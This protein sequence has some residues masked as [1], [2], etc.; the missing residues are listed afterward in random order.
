MSVSDTADFDLI[1]VAVFAVKFGHKVF[2]RRIDRR[3]ELLRHRSAPVEEIEGVVQ[4]LSDIRK[5]LRLLVGIVQHPVRR[6]NI[7]IKLLDLTVKLAK[8]NIKI[9]PFSC[10]HGIGIDMYIVAVLSPVKLEISM[11]TVNTSDDLAVNKDKKL[12]LP[13]LVPNIGCRNVKLKILAFKLRRNLNM[14]VE[15]SVLLRIHSPAF[16]LAEFT[17]VAVR[18]RGNFIS[19][20]VSALRRFPACYAEPYGSDIFFDL[21]QNL[22]DPLVQKIVHTLLRSIIL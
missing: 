9:R 17:P 11:V 22:P 6:F 8:L 1:I 7:V 3:K 18:E 4:V 10:R 15:P 21:L 16:G 19:L 14:L 13:V 5:N 20:F 12:R 2:V